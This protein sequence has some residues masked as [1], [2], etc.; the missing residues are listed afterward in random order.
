MI[1]HNKVKLYQPYFKT[2]ISVKE[3]CDICYYYEPAAWDKSSQNNWTNIK[4]YTCWL[5]EEFYH[6]FHPDKS[7]LDYEMRIYLIYNGNEYVVSLRSWLDGT[8]IQNNK[9][10]Y[11]FWYEIIGNKRIL[12][13]EKG[14][15]K[16]G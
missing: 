7:K 2:Y 9:I 8:A 11:I 6:R 1:D 16:I 3:S 10:N 15:I 13:N 5:D 4:D 12:H 14:S